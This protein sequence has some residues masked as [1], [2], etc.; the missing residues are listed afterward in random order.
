MS[1]WLGRRYDRSAGRAPAFIALA[2][3]AVGYLALTTTTSFVM[4][5]LIAAAFLQLFTLARTHLDLSAG[6]A[7]R[8]GT[9]VLGPGHRAG[10]RAVRQHPHDRLLIS[11]ILAGATA[12]A[13][14]Y[15]GDCCC[16]TPSPPSGRVRSG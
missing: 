15:R 12:Q 8:W 4:L 14:G 6:G 7:A 13:L 3:P 11:G 16:V 9:P 1:A 5:L 10:D 2:A